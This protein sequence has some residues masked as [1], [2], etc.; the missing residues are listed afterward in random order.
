MQA[1]NRS[2]ELVV[3]STVQ[4]GEET[5]RRFPSQLPIGHVEHMPEGSNY[6]LEKILAV[7]PENS[8]PPTAAAQSRQ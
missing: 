5:S 8:V 3:L 7:D 4:D 1:C 6:V 2:D